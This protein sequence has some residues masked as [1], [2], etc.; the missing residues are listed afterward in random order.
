MH[1]LAAIAFV[2]RM[3][4]EVVMLEG[5]RKHLPSET[6]RAVETASVSMSTRLRTQ[7]LVQEVQCDARE[8]SRRLSRRLAR[9]AD[10]V[11]EKHLRSGK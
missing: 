3:F 7:G 5:V 9:A 8:A 2:G 4:F 6:M 11:V 1:L 10:A